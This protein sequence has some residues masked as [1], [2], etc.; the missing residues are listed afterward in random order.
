ME[1][2]N[3]LVVNEWTACK[4]GWAQALPEG[5]TRGQ[6]QIILHPTHQHMLCS[7]WVCPPAPPLAVG[8]ELW[9]REERLTWQLS[10]PIRVQ[11]ALPHVNW[12]GC[13]RHPIVGMS[14]CRFPVTHT[15]YRG[16]T[17]LVFILWINC[18]HC[19]KTVVAVLWQCQWH[20][21]TVRYS[22]RECRC[23]DDSPATRPAHVQITLQIIQYFS[24]KG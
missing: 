3:N 7:Q 23:V 17:R 14:H 5:F 10:R 12:C 2:M 9:G 19:R 21:Y 11:Q 1:E 4:C 8:A 13:S 18:R 16:V 20:M 22:F 6:Q 24:E 15:H